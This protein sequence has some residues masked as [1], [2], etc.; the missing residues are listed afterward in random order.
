MRG[1]EVGFVDRLGNEIGTAA[2]PRCI[3]IPLDNLAI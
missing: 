3:A 2:S 1:C